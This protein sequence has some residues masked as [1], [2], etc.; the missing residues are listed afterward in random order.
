MKAIEGTYAD[1]RFI[2]HEPLPEGQ[3]PCRFVL[4]LDEPSRHA[5]NEA[6]SQAIH[7]VAPPA[8]GWTEAQIEAVFRADD[9]DWGRELDSLRLPRRA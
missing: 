3:G 9:E 1:G 4:L 5:V 6:S 2:L 8:D 7:V